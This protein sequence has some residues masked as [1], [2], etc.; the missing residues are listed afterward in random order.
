M[1][2]ERALPRFAPSQKKSRPSCTTLAG[3][4]ASPSKVPTETADQVEATVAS[5]ARRSAL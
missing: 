3:T 5:S 2:P 1:V 4:M